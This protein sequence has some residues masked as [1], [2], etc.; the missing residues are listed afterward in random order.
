MGTSTTYVFVVSFTICASNTGYRWYVSYLPTQELEA[1]ENAVVL[2]W[3]QLGDGKKT[4]FSL[5]DG[6]RKN[7]FLAIKNNDEDTYLIL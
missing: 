2:G 6:T 5:N 1:G 4:F 7:L 3:G